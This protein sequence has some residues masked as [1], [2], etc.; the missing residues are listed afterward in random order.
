MQ[1]ADET[2]VGE[3]TQQRKRFRGVDASVVG[4]ARRYLDHCFASRDTIKVHQRRLPHRAAAQEFFQI[5]ETRRIGRRHEY[6]HDARIDAGK[7][8][9]ERRSRVDRPERADLAADPRP[10]AREETANQEDREKNDDDRAYGGNY[11]APIV[12][13]RAPWFI[14]PENLP[15]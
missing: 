14:V 5:M 15:A 11:I 1:A 13:A 12:L 6:R 10:V 3:F 2:K 4:S 9:G 7:S 8:V